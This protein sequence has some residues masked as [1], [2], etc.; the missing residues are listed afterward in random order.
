MLSNQK[1]NKILFKYKTPFV[2]LIAKQNKMVAPCWWDQFFAI[3]FL[4]IEGNRADQGHK[5]RASGAGWE[6]VSNWNAFL[7]FI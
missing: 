4:S 2:T 3:S 7:C 6:F 5:G 1:H